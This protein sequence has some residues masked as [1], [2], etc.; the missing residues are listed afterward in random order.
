MEGKSPS[1]CSVKVG[2]STKALPATSAHAEGMAGPSEKSLLA[3]IADACTPNVPAGQLSSVTCSESGRPYRLMPPMAAVTYNRTLETK[4]RL[5]DDGSGCRRTESCDPRGRVKA[6]VCVVVA[7]PKSK[8]V[9]TRLHDTCTP[10]SLAARWY[11]TVLALKSSPLRYV[12]VG[13]AGEPN[14]RVA[15]TEDRNAREFWLTMQPAGM[16]GSTTPGSSAV[17]AW[18]P[19]EDDGEEDEAADDDSADDERTEEDTADDEPVDDEPVDDEP[20]DDETE[21]T[22]AGTVS[23]VLGGQLNSATCTV[24]A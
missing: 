20:V 15:P 5:M 8:G 23:K 22:T 11:A 14:S 4:P 9:V 13:V 6:A 12:A 17:A 2:P 7:V 18:D 16:D 1:S 24:L 21:Q 19:V 3:V 10:Q